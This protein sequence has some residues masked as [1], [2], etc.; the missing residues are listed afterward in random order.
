[1]R[2]IALLP[3]LTSPGIADVTIALSSDSPALRFGAEELSAALT[4]VGETPLTVVGNEGD[5]V[6]RIDPSRAAESY[7]VRRGGERIEVTGDE[8]GAMY[9]LLDVSET[10]TLGRGLAAVKALRRKPFL[11]MR[12]IKWNLPLSG[13]YYAGGE[14][15]RLGEWLWSRD[16]WEEHLRMMARNRYNVLTLW[17]GCPFHHIVHL[18]H[19][20]GSTD[21]PREQV[22]ANID[23]L[24][25][26]TGRAREL[27]IRT[28]LITWNIHI[29]PSLAEELG[30]E[31]KGVDTPE[32]REY[33]REAVKAVVETYPDLTAVGTCPGENMPM[34]AREKQEWIADTHLEGVRRASRTTPFFLR[35][36][37]G[38]PVETARMLDN[39]DWPEPVYLAVKFNGEHMYSSTQPHL[40]DQRWLSSAS[41]RW[42]VFWHL[43]ND[44]IFRLKWGDTDFA[45][46]T[47][48][49][50]RADY[51]CG[52][53]WG[54]EGLKPG[55]DGYHHPDSREFARY[56]WEFQRKS[57][58]YRT[59]GMLGYDPE[60]PDDVVFVDYHRRFGDAAPDAIAALKQAS[61]VIPLV[62]SFHW[63]YM[64]GDW[65]PETNTGS[66]NTNHEATI[67][68]WR[69]PEESFH[70]VKEFI[71]NHTIG[72]GLLSIPDSVAIDNAMI[73]L[74]PGST[75]PEMAAAEII[76]ASGEAMRH[77]ELAQAELQEPDAHFRCL[78]DDVRLHSLLGEYY[79]N[80]I[81]AA[82]D[83][84]WVLITGDEDHRRPAVNHLQECAETWERLIEVAARQYSASRWSDNLDQVE[85]DI[86]YARTVQPIPRQ[87]VTWE[88]AGYD[89]LPES[90]MAL[91]MLD[92][93][94]VELSRLLDR[95]EGAGLTE[96]IARL[97]DWM[98]LDRIDLGAACGRDWRVYHASRSFTAPSDG[99]ADVTLRGEA[100]GEL[101]LGEG[102]PVAFA[103]EDRTRHYLLQVRE[104]PQPLW[105]EIPNG[106][107]AASRTF[108][109]N[110]AFLPVTE[111]VAQFECE[112]AELREP[113]TVVSDPSCSG[114]AYVH[115]P[116]HAGRGDDAEGD[117][118][119][120]GRMTFTMEVPE[121][122]DYDIWVRCLWPATTANS[123]FIEVDDG[124]TVQFGQDE[125]FGVWHWVKARH[126]YHLSPGE[127][128]IALRTRE[129]NTLGDMLLLAPAGP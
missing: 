71:W 100:R 90:P 38:D 67:R 29:P 6:V 97:D 4:E 57:E 118:V 122:G 44:C 85:A 20:A 124:D 33:T 55:A 34:I 52:F 62:T 119:E 96:W 1:M 31:A 5:V 65:A 19:I 11:A 104:G 78:Q 99:M 14:G 32:V 106:Q 60:T 77:I 80:K 22:D 127:H 50:C 98:R 91:R 108:G 114:G 15:G 58:M 28:H 23:F 54:S 36:W 89:R 56:P 10:V 35:Y 25:W 103:P 68:N 45:R 109:L 75:T 129:S 2:A 47:L 73:P 117:P 120:H 81:L 69:D 12:G 24:R 113:M 128:E 37:Q 51:S 39:E 63:N 27:G 43:R 66:W 64:N 93:Q 101:H 123:Y 86:E 95:G 21:L 61:R 42:K 107:G 8:I 125:R 48:R 116:A 83:L 82:T 13:G 30:V 49:N 76:D 17:N 111:V 102:G 18:D 16:F 46:E 7:A 94:E 72:G 121:G 105:A 26:A 88:V 74:G 79:G 87:S 40:Q 126:P 41:G 92:W 70:S 115:S 84:A 53:F 110:I 9:G 59:W 112:S 3:L